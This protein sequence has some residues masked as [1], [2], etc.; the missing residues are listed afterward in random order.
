MSSSGLYYP[1]IRVPDSDWFARCLLYWDAVGSIIPY[2]ELGVDSR[3]VDERMRRLIS[4]GLV[5]PVHPEDH[6][7]AIPRF[8]E[9]FL[10]YLD[11]SRRFVQLAQEDLD[12]RPTAPVHGAKLTEPPPALHG[13]KLTRG[14]L[15][16]L[17]ARGLARTDPRH[18][19]WLQVEGETADLYMAYL[20]ARLCQ[21]PKLQMDPVTDSDARLSHFA[22]TSP[23]VV[24]AARAQTL[25][26]LLPAP[27]KNVDLAEL[28]EFKKRHAD[29]LAELRV[30]VEGACLAIARIENPEL[31]TRE[32]GHL[33][34]KL[35]V[36]ARRL[37]GSMKTRGWRIDPAGTLLQVLTAAG[38]V[39]AGV[40]TGP[41]A[42][43]LVMVPALGVASYTAIRRGSASGAADKDDVIVRFPFAATVAAE[44][45]P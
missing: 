2:D 33:T 20:A 34:D 45:G 14:L 11:S 38:V 16:E 28:R 44:L 18:Q 32:L 4:L 7:P 30:G 6:I 35:Q 8:A 15:D 23:G 31:R 36:Q 40:L 41:V 12:R 1:E 13:N 43:G 29:E 22:M 5:V 27:P 21:T 19:G 24:D 37:E 42:A 17:R 3:R 9:D 26:I 25:K 39:A 10:D